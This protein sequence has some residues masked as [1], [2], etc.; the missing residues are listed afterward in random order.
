[1]WVDFIN[2]RSEAR[3]DLAI[4]LSDTQH[5]K[6]VCILL[7]LGPARLGIYLTESYLSLLT[8]QKATDLDLKK[9]PTNSCDI[10]NLFGI[11]DSIIT[12]F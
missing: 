6:D 4:F 12:R 10:K 2:V 8:D 9:A 7:C 1:M 5:L 3:N 11:E